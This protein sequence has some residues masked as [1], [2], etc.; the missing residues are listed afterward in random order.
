[1]SY[2]ANIRGIKGPQSIKYIQGPQ[3]CFL[4]THEDHLLLVIVESSKIKRLGIC[5]RWTSHMAGSR[6]GVA[7]WAIPLL[8]NI[9]RLSAQEGA[10]IQT[11]W[12]HQCASASL[13]L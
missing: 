8:A 4:V 10:T 1:M 2:I 9:R 12:W 11:R 6:K 7:I 3:T 13:G 5:H